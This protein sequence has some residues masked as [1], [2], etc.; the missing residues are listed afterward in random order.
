MDHSLVLALNRAALVSLWPVATV[1][2]SRY[3]PY[4]LALLFAWFVLRKRADIKEKWRL[5]FEGIGAALI[6][7][8]FVEILR[9]FVHRPRPFAADSAIA[10]LLS[11]TSY[12]FPSGHA[13]FFSRFQRSYFCA[14]EKRG[15]GSLREA[16][17]SGSLEWPP[18]R[19]ICLTFLAA[20]CLALQS[21]I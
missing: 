11:E 6:S 15:G 4:L 2:S 14:T 13:A 20:R 8:G 5:F 10:A 12:S 7:R 17:S 9:L 3:F 19:T 1:F 21:D 18:A 16:R